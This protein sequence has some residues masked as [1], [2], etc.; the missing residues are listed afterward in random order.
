MAC[1][2][3]ELA[4][5]DEHYSLE[6]S[7]EG[8]I[9]NFEKWWG[10]F[11]GTPLGKLFEIAL[12]R[13]PLLEKARNELREIAY[14]YGMKQ[15]HVEHMVSNLN[16]YIKISI[17][18]PDSQSATPLNFSANH[19][20]TNSLPTDFT[21]GQGNYLRIFRLDIL[22]DIFGFNNS[23]RQSAI[24]EITAVIETIRDVFSL[25]RISIA[26]HFTHI[27]SYQLR[28]KSHFH[29][30]SSFE[31]TLQQIERRVKA[32]IHDNRDLES[33]YNV[34]SEAAENIFKFSQSIKQEIHS[35]LNETGIGSIE[36]LLEIVGEEFELPK[37]DCDVLVGTPMNVVLNRPEIVIQMNL[38][39]HICGIIGITLSDRFPKFR[40]D[41]IFETTARSLYDLIK[42]EN[43][44]IA[45]GYKMDQNIFEQSKVTAKLL[46]HRSAYQKVASDYKKV[47]AFAL[48]EVA[49]KMV[50]KGLIKRELSYLES[51]LEA[52][53]KKLEKIKAKL[54]T[55]ATYL[56]ESLETEKGRLDLVDKKI[57]LETEN[58]IST[59]ELVRSLGG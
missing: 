38:L 33:A 11:S 20:I 32:G 48:T 53:E 56:L 7:F 18:P 31:S 52:F 30:S 51:Q 23:W 25:I 42:T 36:E 28:K 17:M 1:V 47:V 59:M 12:E 41:A 39:K 26:K 37:A 14:K 55:S 58:I 44:S 40:I 57:V 2:L 22:I 19:V 9:T 46:M 6:K 16:N 49:D 34:L 5:P 4:V 45:Y 43:Y 3:I 50:K 10:Q 15:E 24:N 21:Q 54:Q 13:S 27:R 35:L 29:L 8:T